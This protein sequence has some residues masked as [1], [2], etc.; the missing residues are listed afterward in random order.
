ML[1]INKH[2]A[3][4]CVVERE[5]IEQP[6]QFV[7]TLTPHCVMLRTSSFRQSIIPCIKDSWSGDHIIIIVEVRS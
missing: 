1:R 4:M 3:R 7:E 2:D 5:S 6:G